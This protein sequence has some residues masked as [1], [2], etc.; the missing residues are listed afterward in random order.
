LDHL[1]FRPCMTVEDQSAWKELQ[2]LFLLNFYYY[3][4]LACLY[5]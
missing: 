5:F 2:I 1:D 3:C 4:L